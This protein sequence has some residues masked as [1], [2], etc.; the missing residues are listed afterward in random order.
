MSLGGEVIN[1]FLT[2]KLHLLVVGRLVGRVTHRFVSGSWTLERNVL[3]APLVD[4]EAANW[5]A[6]KTLNV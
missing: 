5:T 6:E 2:L 1:I 3:V 4:D